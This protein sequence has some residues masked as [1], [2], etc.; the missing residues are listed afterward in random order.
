MRHTQVAEHV[1]PVNASVGRS[2]VGA[3]CLL[4]VRTSLATFEYWHGSLS[5]RSE[6]LGEPTC[7]RPGENVDARDQ[8]SGGES[9]AHVDRQGDS[10]GVA[11]S[12][13]VDSVISDRDER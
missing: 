10:A 1:L 2:T 8:A 11:R 13:D 6:L 5:R 9:T 7:A 12:T 4:S 3:S